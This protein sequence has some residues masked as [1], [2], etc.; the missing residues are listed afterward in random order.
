[1]MK[2]I[3]IIALRIPVITK[4]KIIIVVVLLLII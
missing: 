2:C 4:I 3:L 1:M